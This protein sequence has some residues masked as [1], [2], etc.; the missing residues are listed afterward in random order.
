MG[1]L[2][3]PQS[4]GDEGEAWLLSYADM[5][6]L[7]ACFFILMMAFANFD[8]VGFTKKTEVV[9]QH[10][11]KDKNKSSEIKLNQITEEV[12][13]HPTLE[14]MT[15][16]TRE[17]GNLIISF[18]GTLLFNRNSSKL[19]S[20]GIRNLDLMIELISEINS[21]FKV[22]AEGHSNTDEGNKTFGVWGLS[23][24][25]A[26]EVIERFQYHGFS[27]DRL[28]SL[29]KG[30]STPIVKR[31]ENPENEKVDLSLNQRVVIKLIE[32]PKKV[33]LGLG[34]YFKD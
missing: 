18:S 13:M 3:R 19:N 24:A 23:G 20:E 10:F 30:D 32:I 7:I 22:L 16:I 29:G 12:A 17:N 14:K 2:N 15:K 8:P 27:S 26:A 1:K 9:S 6:T 28:A 34:V 21:N 5:M 31:D 33:K 11:R 25:R 4:G